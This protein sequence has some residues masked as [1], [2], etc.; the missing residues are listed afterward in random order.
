M[1]F[2]YIEMAGLS[3]SSMLTGRARKST[4][5]AR[6][7]GGTLFLRAKLSTF[8]PHGGGFLPVNQHNQQAG[9]RKKTGVYYYS[10]RVPVA[11]QQPKS[12]NRRGMR[13]MD[14]KR[15]GAQNYLGRPPCGRADADRSFQAR[16]S[17][18]DKHDRRLNVGLSKNV[19]IRI[20]TIADVVADFKGL[21]LRESAAAM[22]LN[23]KWR[24]EA[25]DGRLS[26][27]SPC[28]FG[29]F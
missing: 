20:Y 2:I 4:N 7:N 3:A 5:F 1:R 27:L 13:A 28:S 6:R 14:A 12:P 9:P 24:P 22:R 19:Y 11:Q 26:F 8:A 29:T 10:C 17:L 16:P 21:T 15:P 23:S 18:N 25:S